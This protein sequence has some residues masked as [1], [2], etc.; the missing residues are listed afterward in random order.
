MTTYY[1]SSQIGNDNNA[2]TSATAPLATLQTA[3]NVVKPGDT[4][5][6]MNGTYTGG[7]G[8]DVV[9]I[10]TSGTASA[11]I[12]FMTAPGQTPVIDSTDCWNAINIK[13]SY[14][15]IDGF[16]VVGNAATITQQDALANS[17]PGKAHYD[18]NGI[19]VL[20]SHVTVENCTVHDEPGGGI[21]T[22]GVDYVQ[23]L[24]NIVY[25]NAHWSAY[26]N[27]GISVGASV[28]LDTAAGAHFVISGNTVYNN[29]ELVPEYRANAITD[30]EGIILDSNS[31]YTSEMLVQNNTVYGN[32]GPGI[33]AFLTD[34]AVI[35][36]NTI[37][38]NNTQNL[39]APSNAQI[40][41]NQSNNV[42]VTN[43]STGDPNDHTPPNPPVI[44]SDAMEINVVTLTGTAEAN[45]TVTLFDNST[46]LGTATTSAN[47]A[48]TFTT[49]LLA[50]GSQSFTATATD[51]SLNVSAP[52][53]PLVV[54]VNAPVTLVVNGSFE[55]NSFIGWTLGGNYTSTTWG[56]EI[57]IDTN[58]ESG[59][60]AAAMGSVGSDGTLSQ[61]IAT[62]PGQQY[63]LSFWLANEG[64][65]PNDF[66]ATWNGQALLALTN[67]AA[68]GYTEYT[69][70]VTAT[71]ST[72]ALQFSARQD[73]SHWDLDSISLTPVGSQPPPPP[74]TSSNLVIN[75]GFE[76]GDFTG[77]TTS[78]NVAQSQL[79]IT[80]SARSGQDAA[81]LGSVGSD[82]TI[83]QNLT[84]VVGQSYTLDFW[85]ANAA[86]GPNDF[87]A[88]IGGV[89]ELHLVNAAAQ[90]YT[91]Y[92]FTFT[93]TSTS[94][95]LE[96][97]FRQD[98]SAW[99]LDDV[100]VVQATGSAPPPPPPTPPAAPVI[101]SFS[102]DT[103]PVGDGHTTA[104]SITLTGTGE[105][106]S[107]VNVFD[108]TT[109]VGH[110]SVNASGAWSLPDSGL[111][112]GAHNFTATADAN[113]TSAASAVFAVTVDA[114]TAP[115][116]S[117]VAANH[118]PVV[119]A[120]DVTAGHNH[121]HD[122]SAWQEFHAL[123]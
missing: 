88:K 23:I 67:S 6:V 33:E 52:S 75:G 56:P 62:T 86:G 32:G 82:G 12:T 72:T 19:A 25:N 11:P 80:S 48:W 119:T 92:D 70:T 118:L 77:W 87:T 90:P 28:N 123:V 74:P 42:T 96:F 44:S 40:F 84:T 64:G 73:P 89:T 78:G 35:A 106:N 2:G 37:Y 36:G 47:G 93:A 120:S 16:T 58:A 121:G 30:G 15:V 51:A 113:G 112:V 8:A 60:Y 81:G 9:D 46:Q 107:T 65:G 53:S 110:A 97:D 117:P 63:T 103:A 104:T 41:I 115:S 7:A 13:A 76:T 108:G 17:S 55:T 66:T 57:V 114:P 101:A 111:T 1:V 54:V 122:W 98:P 21:F 99:Q 116:S 31:G 27:S 91:H 3:A 10:T 71:G 20:A 109:S 38:G 5:Q 50:N 69:Y 14:I 39:Q 18:G 34:N 79:F 43:N 22:S 94:T 85:L 61:S 83:S 45:S 29:A 49:G 100:S 95:P 102:S 26:G 68:F 105:A 59:R 4:V 24:N